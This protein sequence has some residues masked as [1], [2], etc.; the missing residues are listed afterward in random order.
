M[1]SAHYPRAKSNS[2]RTVTRSPL[3]PPHV[4][5]RFKIQHSG[6]YR[7]R[8]GSSGILW[9]DGNLE[10]HRTADMARDMPLLT[11]SDHEIKAPEGGPFSAKIHAGRDTRRRDPLVSGPPRCSSTHSSKERPFDSRCAW[12]PGQRGR[13]NEYERDFAP[14]LC[15]L[16]AVERE[17]EMG[18]GRGGGKEGTREGSNGD[19]PPET[20]E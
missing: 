15:P 4:T 2:N 1:C 13:C 7:S 3:V 20:G 19:Y 6:R 17:R 14:A 5:R 9:S 12:H 18:A 11:S 10:S 16:P 8:S